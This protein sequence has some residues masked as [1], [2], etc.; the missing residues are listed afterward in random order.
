MRHEPTV[1]LHP[2]FQTLDE[3]DGP[4]DW[5]QFFG[6]ENPVELD[7]GCGRGMFLVRASLANPNVNYV[8]V[9]IDYKEGR[10]AARRLWKR[11]LPNARVLGGDA[12]DFLRKY[13]P[14]HSVSAVH[15]YFP[16]PWWKRKHKKRRL[17][18]HVFTDLLAW[19]L[20]EGGEVHAWTDVEDYFE[21]IQ[22]L[23]DHHRHF[24]PLPPPPE[25]QPQHDMDYMTSFERKKRKEGK[26]I[27]RGRWRR[28]AVDPSDDAPPELIL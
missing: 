11:S 26:T 3:L 5:V 20:K 12:R 7:I 21:V 14:P 9:E 24:E 15:V 10:R 17:F 13:V 18:N 6:N 8:G 28:G 25:H 22:A 4:I 27:Y 1:D 2:Y 19:V 16:D 23:M